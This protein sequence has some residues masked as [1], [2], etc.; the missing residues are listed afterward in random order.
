MTKVSIID[1]DLGE[2]DKIISEDVAELHGEAKEKLETAIEERKKVEK[3][4]I[5]REQAKADEASAI[6]NAM[7]AAYEKLV[8]AG[9][10]GVP[11]ED[12]LSIVQPAIANASA[13]TLRMKKRLREEG[14]PYAIRRKQ[15]KKVPHYIFEPFNEQPE[16]DGEDS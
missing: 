9:A 6:N 10:N 5:Q 12:I 3:V 15:I 2:I 14:N 4:R 8:G 13:F 16:A 11:S 1:I 7:D